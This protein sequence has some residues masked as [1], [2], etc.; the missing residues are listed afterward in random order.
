MDIEQ[1]IADNM[2]LV[3]KQLHKFNRINDEDAYSYAVEALYKAIE[4]YDSSNGTKLST[5]ASVCIYNGIAMYLRGEVTRTSRMSVVSLEETLYDDVTRA[6]TICSDEE[7][8]DLLLK[9]EL[10]SVLHASFDKVL[11]KV[12][13]SNTRA[14]IEAWRDSEFTAT[15]SAISEKVGVSQAQVSRALSAFKYKLKKEMEDY[16]CNR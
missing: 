1:L 3:Y 12:T 5:Y 6:D 9:K 7:A 8:D 15:Q 14:I 11:S 4:T 16:L 2:G 13:S 10:Y